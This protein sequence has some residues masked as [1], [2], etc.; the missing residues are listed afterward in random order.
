MTISNCVRAYRYSRGRMQSTLAAR[1]NNS[2]QTAIAIE[3]RRHDPILPKAFE[4]IAYFNFQIDNLFQV[5]NK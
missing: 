4:F 1:L 5:Y 3:N 2:H